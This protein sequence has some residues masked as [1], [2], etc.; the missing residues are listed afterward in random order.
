MAHNR[1]PFSL[2]NP[3]GTGWNFLFHTHINEEGQAVA[4]NWCHHSLESIYLNENIMQ[5]SYKLWNWTIRNHLA[6][7]PWEIIGRDNVVLS[8]RVLPSNCDHYRKTLL[9]SSFIQ[10]SKCIWKKSAL[11]S[12][13][14][15]IHNYYILKSHPMTACICMGNDKYCTSQPHLQKLEICCA[16]LNT[17]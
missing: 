14:W 10:V 15:N 5:P 16:R 17:M 8:V 4:D 6:F 13:R 7:H 12:A 9:R 3:L 2:C 11:S 1:I